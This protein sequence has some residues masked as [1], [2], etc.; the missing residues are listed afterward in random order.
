MDN[1]FN[2]IKYQDT[3]WNEFMDIVFYNGDFLLRKQETTNCIRKL[4]NDENFR[5][6]RYFVMF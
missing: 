2:K 1:K 4:Y 6:K 5:C 3:E